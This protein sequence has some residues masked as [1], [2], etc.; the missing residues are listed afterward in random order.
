MVLQGDEEHYK[1]LAHDNIERY[2]KIIAQAK[3][4]K[5]IKDDTIAQDVNDVI[6]KVMSLTNTLAKNPDKYADISYDIC[7]LTEQIYSTSRYDI[8]KRRTIGKNGLLPTFH[9]YLRN[10]VS[11]AKDG[12]YDFQ[13]K[14]ADNAKE[15]IK[16]QIESLKQQIE[17]IE[18]KL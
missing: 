1:K 13:R 12:G 9:T 15:S 2:K 6:N 5:A 10:Q 11:V 7:S 18:A 16:K 14:D 8:Q 17:K 3:A 4:E